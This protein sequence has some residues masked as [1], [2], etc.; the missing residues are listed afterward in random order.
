M[1][2]LISPSARARESA[3]AVHTATGVLTDVA[4]AF[5]TALGHLRSQEYTLVVIDEFLL[6]VDPDQGAQVLQ[7][8]DGAAPL[9]VSFAISGLD[10]LVRE[11]CGALNRRKKEKEAARA[12][13][14][15]DLWSELNESVTAMLLSCDLALA[16]PGLSQGAAEKVRNIHDLVENLRARLASREAEKACLSAGKPGKART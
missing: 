15:H 5:D 7:H 14:E 4:V 6:E 9:Y 3:Q 11:V 2:L 16:T 13:A 10:R 1:I 8:L 12:T